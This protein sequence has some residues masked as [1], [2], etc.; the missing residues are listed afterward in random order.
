MNN[1]YQTGNDLELTYIY[2]AIYTFKFKKQK[3]TF[4]K[5]HCPICFSYIRKNNV[6]L[7]C[8]HNCCFPCFERFIK[9]SY[10]NHIMPICF[11]CRQD[12]ISLEVKQD[13]HMEKIQSLVYP[14]EEEEKIV[15]YYPDLHRVPN[16]RIL[17]LILQYTFFCYLFFY[18]F[19]LV[20]T[21]VTS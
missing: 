9:R 4:S 13:E 14:L 12:I 3:R 18:M 19:E 17:Y 11:I 16:R 5:R 10:N 8:T 1:Q 21:S 2:N 6:V 7:N 20:K 15:T